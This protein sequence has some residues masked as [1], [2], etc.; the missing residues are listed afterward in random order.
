MTIHEYNQMTNHLALENVL[1]MRQACDF[2]SPFLA[3]GFGKLVMLKDTEKEEEAKE[4]KSEE[5]SFLGTLQHGS[6]KTVNK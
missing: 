4:T 3:G 2:P 6:V 1:K 5:P